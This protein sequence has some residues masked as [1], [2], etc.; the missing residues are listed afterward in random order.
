[1]SVERLQDQWSSFT[2]FGSHSYPLTSLE[3]SILFLN[4]IVILNGSR[5]I[6]LTCL[7]EVD[8][9]TPHFFIIKLGCTGIYI[10]FALKQI[11]GTR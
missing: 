4:Y 10:I 5:S 9:L 8:P 11:V 6:M 3:M 2:A 1:M 7:W